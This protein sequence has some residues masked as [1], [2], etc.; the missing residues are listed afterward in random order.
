MDKFNEYL[1]MEMSKN[2]A[3]ILLPERMEMSEEEI[4]RDLEEMKRLYPKKIRFVSAMVEDSCDKLEY[5]G[6]PMF[7]EYP[8]RETIYQIA[9]HVYKHMREEGDPEEPTLECPLYQIIM[10]MLCNEFHCRRC[11]YKRRVKRF[12]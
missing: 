4:F 3:G 6:S 7:H 1:G 10:I 2:W 8:D 11:R 9:T 5:E 12:Y